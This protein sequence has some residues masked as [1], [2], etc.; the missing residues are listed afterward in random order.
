MRSEGR[1]DVNFFQNSG[2]L[3]QPG[4][5]GSPDKRAGLIA[6]IYLVT[7]LAFGVPAIIAGVAVTRYGLRETTDVYGLVVMALAALTTVAVWRRRASP[8]ATV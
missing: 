5:S 8:A 7:Y 2:F 3:P 4:V 6:S 1:K